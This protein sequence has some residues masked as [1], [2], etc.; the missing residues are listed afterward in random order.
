VLHFMSSLIHF[1]PLT[2][3]DKSGYPPNE[4][5]LKIIKEILLPLP[6]SG[7]TVKASARVV[8]MRFRRSSFPILQSWAL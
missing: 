2:R 7:G 4:E 6:E 3:P 1:A 5:R 8:L